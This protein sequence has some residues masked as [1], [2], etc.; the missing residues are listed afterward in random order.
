MSIL[1]RD[2]VLVSKD[3]SGNTIIDMPVTRVNNVEGLGRNPGTAYSVGDVVMCS[4]SKQLQLICTKA[5]T[6]STADLDIS[7]NSAGDTINDG[8]VTWLATK[9]NHF[10][11]SGVLPISEG[12]TGADNASDACANIGALPTSGGDA[13]GL[14]THRGDSWFV[15]KGDDISELVISGASE[16]HHG[17]FLALRGNSHPTLPQG[18]FALFAD[19]G[20]GENLC[21]LTGY[22]DGRLT[23]INKN[24]VRS[25]NGNY[26]GAN[27][28]VNFTV[29][30]GGN[31]IRFA[32]NVQ[33]VWDEVTIPKDVVSLDI[34][35]P[36][37]FIDNNVKVVCSANTPD[38]DIFCTYSNRTPTGVKLASKNIYN[39]YTY[40]VRIVSY[41]AMGYW[42]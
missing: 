3:E 10:N 34:T 14:I 18:S 9:I 13:T 15:R 41:V 27:G 12:G 25:V 21:D 2:C 33:I 11:N 16:F 42:I 37:P 1:E 26:A 22:K 30:A 17:A 31:Y 32:N 35:F 6:T 40:G 5:G 23:W 8:T 4:G 36:L 38:G 28:D 19:T 39:Q 20:D 29:S 24:I 7:A